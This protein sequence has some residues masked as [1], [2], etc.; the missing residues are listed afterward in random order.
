MVS[1]TK[2][3]NKKWKERNQKKIKEYNKKWKENHREILRINQRDYAN[4]NRKYYREKLKRSNLKNI[5]NGYHA[6]KQ[7]EY[8]KRYPKKI[9]AHN[10]TNRKIQLK[11]SCDICDSMEKLEKHH[12]N[13]NKPLI[14]N[15]LCK[16]C[17][18]IQ[19]TKKI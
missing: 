3:Y 7:K 14:V 12:W 11:S 9:K 17:H 5:L 4:K 10:L 8:S 16:T 13:Y 1:N 19:H 18:S 15:T 2:E 6:L